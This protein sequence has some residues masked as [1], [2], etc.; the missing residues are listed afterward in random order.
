MEGKW[1]GR[2]VI[3]GIISPPSR[4]YPRLP[5]EGILSAKSIAGT[6]EILLNWR[7]TTNSTR[8]KRERKINGATPLIGESSAD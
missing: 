6:A 7:V 2:T 1:L 5:L 4:T 8:V 3:C